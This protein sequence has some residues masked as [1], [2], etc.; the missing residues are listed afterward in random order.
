MRDSIRISLKEFKSEFSQ[1]HEPEKVQLLRAHR[2]WGK[3]LE[4]LSA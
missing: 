2:V 1:S 3:K 4:C